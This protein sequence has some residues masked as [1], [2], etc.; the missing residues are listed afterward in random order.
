MNIS[1]SDYLKKL[2]GF[3][4]KEEIE[5]SFEN[6]QEN[7][8]ISTIDQ[9]KSKIFAKFSVITLLISIGFSIYINNFSFS[10]S[11]FI[12]IG[13]FINE[14][15]T[16]I[17]TKKYKTNI[18][19]VKFLK[20]YRFFVFYFS[21]VSIIFLL[22]HNSDSLNSSFYLR[23][24]YCF[25]FMMNL[26]S[27]FCFDNN[28]VILAIVMILNCLIIIYVQLL[29][30][31]E[32]FYLVPEL[33]INLM[34]NFGSYFLKDYEVS[35]KK[36]I[37]LENHK[38][39]LYLEYF[40]QFIDSMK[41]MLISMQKNS[42]LYMNKYALNNFPSRIEDKECTIDNLNH[43]SI[44]VSNN[45]IN[46]F[47]G[48][49]MSNTKTKI[50]SIYFDENTSLINILYKINSS[51]I[52]SNDF[53]CIG[54]FTSHSSTN[55]YYIYFRKLKLKIEVVEILI[56][57][58]MEIRLQEKIKDENKLNKI[59]LLK[60]THE[61]KTPLLT[62]TSIIKNI[63]ELETNAL[64]NNLDHINNLSNYAIFLINDINLYVI[65]SSDLNITK[66]KINIIDIIN[67][68][69][70]IL[71]TLL[72]CNENKTN[73]IKPFLV[74]D[75]NIHNLTI[76]SHDKHLKQIILNLISN[77][78]K[79]TK[80]GFIKIEAK[81]ISLY[82]S[83][84]ICVD[85][86]GIGIKDPLFIFNKSIHKD[87]DYNT[88]GSGLG[89]QICKTLSDALN[90]K[91]TIESVHNEG[92]KF[93][94]LIECSNT[95]IIHLKQTTNKIDSSILLSP[96]KTR[97]NKLLS[98]R[99]CTLASDHSL[100]E[101]SI[102]KIPK[103]K[104][105]S[106]SND[107][108]FEIIDNKKFI[109]SKTYRERKLNTNDNF[110]RSKTILMKNNIIENKTHH[111]V[112]SDNN[113]SKILYKDIEKDNYDQITIE[114]SRFDLFKPEGCDELLET[115]RS[116]R[117]NE[118]EMTNFS[119]FI[120]NIEE[121]L[122]IVVVDDQKI[123]RKNTVNVI[124]NVLLILKIYDIEIIELSDGIEL[125]N[126]IIKDKN[127][128]IIYIFTD[129]NMEFLNG[130]ETVRIIRK[131]EANNKIQNYPIASITAFEDTQTR[132]NIRNSGVNSIL[133]KP[134]NKSDITNLLSKFFEN[135]D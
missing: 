52:V 119:I 67:F 7:P 103:I 120:G 62:I 39:N 105:E 113:S 121:N 22:L 109:K 131:M 34:F 23:F 89:L 86:S 45:Y 82:N 59:I 126:V 134:C 117:N 61:I 18:K 130:S 76:Y 29:S 75:E 14:I 102:S 129:E 114:L 57:E 104:S 92:T 19:L 133:T 108:S 2:I 40:K 118:L 112:N 55:C 10:F 26:L 43:N 106:K 53:N 9:V 122:K 8:R 96:G 63:K 17:L 69:F 83:V 98:M 47:F 41:F 12:L 48:S 32:R 30:N 80:S 135:S 74:I 5:N 51:N 81:F 132:Q 42:K 64:D 72:E 6:L 58:I 101:I 85:D 50:D 49:L 123:V 65:E 60:I 25:I 97:C 46:D 78:F 128:Q 125:L 99:N 107:N 35:E 56:I 27:S 124:K 79:F 115:K 36:E 3:T 15:L 90:H 70:N 91:L 93:K 94:L 4:N 88:Q 95:E 127:Y 33:I 31:L 11:T 77:A 100:F 66:I 71:K 68:S 20:V 1:I 24:L 38:T 73:K 110:P 37:L 111:F 116:V 13:E 54:N 21:E 44:N 84:E 87:Q 16:T 28:Y